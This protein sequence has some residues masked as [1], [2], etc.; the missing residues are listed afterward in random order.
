VSPVAGTFKV[1]NFE[2]DDDA[3]TYCVAGC[4]AHNA[5]TKAAGGRLSDPR[6]TYVVGERGWEIVAGGYVYSHAQSVMLAATGAL[7]GQT[8]LAA[9]GFVS[10]AAMYPA[11][12]SGG[13]SGAGRTITM[14]TYVQNDIDRQ[15]FLSTLARIIS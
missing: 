11:Q 1:Y 14:N 5:K 2:V 3:H 6:G 12:P 8:R 15:A 9:G 13:G 4:V 10:P 7:A